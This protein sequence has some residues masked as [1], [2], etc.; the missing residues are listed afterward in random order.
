MTELCEQVAF[1]TVS[2]ADVECPFDHDWA[3]PQPFDNELIG[4][5]ARLAECMNGAASTVQYPP[6][7]PQLT[8]IA[9][10]GD[11]YKRR[12]PITI[13]GYY[14]DG[15]AV[16]TKALNYPV[17]CAAH[18]LI[19]AQ[20][21]LRECKN[22]L[23][24]MVS[25]HGSGDALKGQGNFNGIVWSDIGYNVNGSENGHYL[26]GLYAVAGN[27]TC[28]WI[29]APSVLDEEDEEGTVAWSPPPT[30]K[31]VRLMTDMN[32]RIDP[33]SK[34]W[35]YVDRATTLMGAQFHDSHPAYSKFVL[36]V[37]NKIATRLNAA[38]RESVRDLNC[39]KCKEREE[40]IKD[41]G[42]PPPFGLSL[43]L[44]GVSERLRSNLTGGHAKGHRRIFTSRWGLAWA[45]QQ[46]R[47]S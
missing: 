30:K 7:K 4:T 34:K 16:K 32:H 35:Q 13:I 38:R 22:L 14:R 43:R 47:S 29:G 1:G 9:N 31:R 12:K 8:A 36:G 6:Y 37:L 39:G 46:R 15:G 11:K 17:T 20:A 24:F 3:E 45:M 44:N 10:P 25:K 40:K 42:V 18:H 41:F 19:P 26:P 23:K 27:G 28:E 21:S 2:A 5:G 33:Q